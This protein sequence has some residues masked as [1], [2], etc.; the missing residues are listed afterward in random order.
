MGA[1]GDGKTFDTEALQKALDAC[2]KAGGGVVLLP[3]GTYLCDPLTLRT[4]T[5]L[6]LE[7]GA[8]LQATSEHE[9]FV[10]TDKP[11]AFHPF[12]GGKDLEDVTIEGEGVIDGAD[13][14]H[15]DPDTREPEPRDLDERDE[16]VDVVVESVSDAEPETDRGRAVTEDAGQEAEPEEDVASDEPQPP[17][18]VGTYNSGDNKYVMFSDGSI[19]AQTPSGVFRFE[20]LNELKE[21]I[22]AGGEG[23]SPS[24]T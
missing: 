11:D 22:A 15:R 5:T 24:S 14:Y 8:T 12:L 1:T 16:V 6:R 9:P 19:E 2:G 4:K 17:V 3:A 18:V 21:F 13:L 20:S 23:G 10:R 7:K